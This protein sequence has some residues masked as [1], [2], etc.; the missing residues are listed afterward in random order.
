M[1]QRIVKWNISDILLGAL[2]IDVYSKSIIYIYIDSL[3][4]GELYK[5]SLVKKYM[6]Y[7]VSEQIIYN[8]YSRFDCI[9]INFA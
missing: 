9:W 3:V 2:C 5:V 8:I 4:I 7:F 1:Y 6:V